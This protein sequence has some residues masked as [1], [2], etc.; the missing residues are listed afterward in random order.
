MNSDVLDA[1]GRR[2]IAVFYKAAFYDRRADARI[3]RRYTVSVEPDGGWDKPS[4]EPRT[5]VVRVMD[6]GTVIHE[7]A[8]GVEPKEPREALLAFYNAT[9]IVREAAL[10]WLNENRPNHDKFAAWED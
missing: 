8:V 5:M 3:L 6:G 4:P 9:E 10:V 2:R 1:K 7:T